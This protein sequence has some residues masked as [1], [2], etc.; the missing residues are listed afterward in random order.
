MKVK[1]N[2]REELCYTEPRGRSHISL[3]TACK[4]YLLHHTPSTTMQTSSIN[5]KKEMV[6]CRLHHMHVRRLQQ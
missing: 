3:I 6:K 2:G 4:A 5:K 1:Y